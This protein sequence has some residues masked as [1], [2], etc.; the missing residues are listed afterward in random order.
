[1]LIR[2]GKVEFAVQKAEARYT[3]VPNGTIALDLDIVGDGPARIHLTLSPPPLRGR[4]LADLVGQFQVISSPTKPCL[5]DARS[6]TTVAGIYVGRH[7]DVY[8]SCIEWLGVDDSGISLRWTGVV[9]DLNWYEGSKPRQSL[10]VEVV[11]ALVEVPH[12]PVIWIMTCAEED[13]APPLHRIR[14]SL[15][16]KLG[17]E[18]A[19]RAWFDGMPFVAIELVVQVDRWNRRWPSLPRR[20]KS[21]PALIVARVL[22]AVVMCGDDA[23]LQRA[24]EAEVAAGLASIQK[25]YRRSLPGQI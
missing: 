10:V 25:R 23:V 14:A 22:R 4:T 9:N 15:L 16:P 5:Y 11:A 17:A 12:R 24:V 6:V 20:A 19:E 21:E 8:D 3:R 2:V 18:L 1:M 7:D 13:E